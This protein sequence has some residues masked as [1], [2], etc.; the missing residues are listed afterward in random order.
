V[1]SIDIQA[2]HKLGHAEAVRAAE[3][4]SRDLAEKF[5]IAYHWEGEVIHF[6]RPGIH[7]RIRVQDSKLAVEAHLGMMLALLKDSIEREIVRYLQR[8][9]GCRFR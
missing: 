3:E 5:A 9:F 8:H 7:G 2:T 6:E 4:L 1:S